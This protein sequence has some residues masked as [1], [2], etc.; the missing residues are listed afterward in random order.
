M[1][2]FDAIII[3]F[4]KAGKDLAIELAKKKWSVAL[5]ER[6]PK[7]YG[8]SCI[9]IACVPTKRLVQESKIAQLLS[10]T[11]VIDRTGIYRNAIEKK[12]DLTKILRSKAL[13]DISQHP[14]IILFNGVASFVS[15]SIVEVKLE[16]S[17]E[18]LE[19][20]EI[21]INTGS[22][23]I[24]PAIDGLDSCTKAYT[25]G[26]LLELNLLPQHL[27]I[28]G[29]GAAGMEF[30]SIYNNFGSKVTV[31]EALPNFMPYADRDFAGSVQS[32]FEKRGVEMIFN[33]QIISIADTNEGAAVTYID[34]NKGDEYTIE[35]DAILIATGR[36]PNTKDL[37]LEAAGVKIAET[38]AI[39]VD[40][41]LHTEVPHIWAMGDVRG[42]TMSTAVAMDD[43]RIILN[44]LF[45]DDSR[46]IDD[47]MPEPHAYFTDPPIAYIGI[48]EGE[49]IKKGY[50]FKVSRLLVNT[51]TRSHTLKQTEGMM[52]AIVN[53]D[54]NRIIG[55]A[56]FCTDA[57]EII[58]LVNMAMKQELPYTFM[59]DFIFTHPS[60]SEA[61]NQLFDME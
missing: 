44:R 14:E 46:S 25:T 53:A 17:I 60:M 50:N 12:N 23:C 18:Q 20:K 24:T 38:G 36:R 11:D 40:S 42:G 55:C 26:Q 41:H 48:T 2:Q 16:D 10:Q 49:A 34:K 19:G 27:I 47:R 7:M 52:K 35:G 37:H 33:S 28:I 56:L 22:E 1:K 3:G 6:S 59:R 61:F 9:N 32:V 30:A 8:G 43:C 4:G 51:V 21:F 13:D 29:A 15:A 57:P 39:I 31:V 58:N 45:G 5:I 54:T